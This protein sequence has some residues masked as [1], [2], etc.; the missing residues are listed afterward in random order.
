MN[1]DGLTIVR[2]DYNAPGTPESV[3]NT[4][5][6][7]YV[8]GDGFCCLL[9]PDPAAGIYGCGK[10]EGQAMAEFDRLFQERFEKPV[11]GDPVSDFIQQRHI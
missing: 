4:R 5:P 2:I 6:V 11:K 1:T 9:G 3:K 8:N 7:L 10:T